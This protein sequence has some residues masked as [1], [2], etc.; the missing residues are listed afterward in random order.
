M[1]L[2]LWG[3]RKGQQEGHIE[4]MVKKPTCWQI[5][6]PRNVTEARLG[7]FLILDNSRFFAR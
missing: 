6:T 3:Q 2:T 5:Q 1:P 7:P 4:G